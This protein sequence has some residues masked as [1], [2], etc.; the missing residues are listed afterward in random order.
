MESQNEVEETM[1]LSFEAQQAFGEWIWA[2]F[3]PS[4]NKS[5]AGHGTLRMD[6]LKAREA[7]VYCKCGHAL[8]ITHAQY[9]EQTRLAA[10]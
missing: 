7:T 5:N 3:D 9:V 8:T 6:P 10:A 1:D 2:H 4:H